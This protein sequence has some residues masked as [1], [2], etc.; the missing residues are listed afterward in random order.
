VI[1]FA[2]PAQ[3]K[4]GS[5]HSD[6]GVG[7]AALRR[8]A[9]RRLLI[10]SPI[11]TLAFIARGKTRFAREEVLGITARNSPNADMQQSGSSHPRGP[12]SAAISPCDSASTRAP[13]PEFITPPAVRLNG[14]A[15]AV[16]QR[17]RR[18]TDPAA[19][20][21]SKSLPDSCGL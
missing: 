21:Y 6:S 13:R 9:S 15:K 19:M 20:S 1:T 17:S 8:R 10:L 18:D 7:A 3:I 2:R 16:L 12:A 5:G 11:W 4:N 14:P